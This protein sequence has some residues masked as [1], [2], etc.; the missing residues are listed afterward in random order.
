[1]RTENKIELIDRL[2]QEVDRQLE[3]VVNQFQSLSE[4]KLLQSSKTGCWSIAQNL[5][6]LNMYFE[7]YIPQIE[8]A[9]AEATKS[10]SEIEF[11]STWLG[12]YFTKSM[13]YRT[14]KKIKAF[15]DYIP[16]LDLNTAKVISEFIE[17]QET[18]LQQIRKSKDYNLSKIKIAIS[19][20]KLIKLRLGDV[21]QFVVMHNERHIVQA[22]A[23]HS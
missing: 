10:N 13:D 6:H 7:Y 11:K 16:D 21:F 12:S 5:K 15:K 1:M 3:I 18:L 23:V 17:H 14:S 2:E 4:A 19:L 22:Q 9:L 8:R 20:T